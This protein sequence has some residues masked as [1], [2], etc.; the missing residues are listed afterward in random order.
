[1]PRPVATSTPM[2]GTVRVSP[3][4]DRRRRAGQLP[5]VIRT[6]PPDSGESKVVS[7]TMKTGHVVP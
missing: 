6:H 4:G 3:Q 1:M 2:C 7:V 5:P